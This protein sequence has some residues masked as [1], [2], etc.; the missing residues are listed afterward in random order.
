MRSCE[1]F[2][3]LTLGGQLGGICRHGGDVAARR[4][5]GISNGQSVLDAPLSFLET[6]IKAER[7]LSVAPV[8]N[9]PLAFAILPP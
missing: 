9:D 4:E 2:A 7:L 1:R 6:H 8:W 3:Q 5:I